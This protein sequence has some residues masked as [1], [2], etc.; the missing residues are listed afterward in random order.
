[1]SK[2]VE[3]SPTTRHEGHSKL[4][5]KVNDDGI[6]ERGD[7]LSIT[8]VRGVEKLAI[9][10]TMEQ[11]PK[12]ASRVCGIC[13]IAHTLAA[14]EAMEASI[15]CE[16]PEDA[17]L[18]R[19]MLQCANRIHSHAL[20]NILTL[21]D[22]YLPGTDTKINPFTP[23]EPVRSVAKRIQT[24]RMVGQ[25]IG[26][27]V[28]GEAIHPS[29]PRVGG[30]YKNLSPRG[31]AKVLDLAKMGLP[32]AREHMEFM[33]AIL[34]NYQKRDWAEVGGK[35]IPIPKDLGYHNQGYM[36]ADPCYGSSSL[37]ENPRWFPERWTEVRPWDWY[38]GE[39]E[40]TLEDPSYPVGG[41]TKAGT[42]AWP[43]M[44]ACTGVPL[45]DGQPVEVGPRARLVEFKNYDEKGAIGLQIARQMEYMDCFY[46]IIE[47]ADALDCS[48]SVVADEIPQGDG[49][50]G[51]AA[52]EAP[53]GCDVHLAKVRNG[54][55][56]YFSMLVPTTWNFPTC[57]RALVGAP[58]QLTE[59]I[60]RAYDPCVS[61][62]TH[63]IVLDEDKRLVAEKLLE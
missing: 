55:V 10:K 61:C 24:L 37:D 9:G 39:E 58:W 63:M 35:E 51:W 17:Y 3:I 25:T 62:A 38:M 1:M 40:I 33:I 43:Q 12:I 22:M 8:P 31:R 11:V 2:V 27:I 6:V 46:K 48:A 18:L 20:H 4:V 53:R 47:A 36:A 7:W 21:P 56:E 44:E 16:I 60:M 19:L 15:G 14:T 41:T 45:Y 59:V 34:R 54:K 57:S 52:N 32:L 49:S 13:P 29:N 30:M 23:E 26:E 28:G 5:L 50:I 42:K